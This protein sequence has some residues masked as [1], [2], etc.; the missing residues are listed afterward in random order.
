[1]KTYPTKINRNLTDIQSYLIQQLILFLFHGYI[2]FT[3]FILQIFS[4]R[5]KKLSFGVLQKHEF[6]HS[7]DGNQVREALRKTTVNFKNLDLR[8]SSNYSMDN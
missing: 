1:M 2:F 7:K 6:P 3:V 5:D 4:V 8:G